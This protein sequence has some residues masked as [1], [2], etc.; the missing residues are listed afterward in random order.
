MAAIQQYKRTYWHE[1]KKLI[2][3]FVQRV[4]IYKRISDHRLISHPNDLYL[5]QEMYGDYIESLT[6]LRFL[7]RVKDETGQIQDYL[8]ENLD[9]YSTAVIY[10]ELWPIIKYEI[11][12]IHTNPKYWTLWKNIILNKKLEDIRFQMRFVFEH[13]TENDLDYA[14]NELFDICPIMRNANYEPIDKQKNQDEYEEKMRRIKRNMEETQQYRIAI[15][16]S[17]S[18]TIQR[19][20][21]N[22]TYIYG[23]INNKGVNAAMEYVP[24]IEYNEYKGIYEVLQQKYPR[25]TSLVKGFFNGRMTNVILVGTSLLNYIND[26]MDYIR[27]TINPTYKDDLVIKLIDDKQV[28][29]MNHFYNVNRQIR[30]TNYEDV[31]N[32]LTCTRMIDSMNVNEQHIYMY[33]LDGTNGLL[34]MTNF[35]SEY[36]LIDKLFKPFKIEKIRKKVRNDV[37]FMFR[38]IYNKQ[39]VPESIDRTELMDLEEITDEEPIEDVQFVKSHINERFRLNKHDMIFIQRYFGSK[40]DFINLMKTNSEYYGVTDQLRRNPIPLETLKDKELF[41]NV[42]IYDFHREES[43]VPTYIEMT[44]GSQ[45]GQ[46]LIKVFEILLYLIRIELYN[47]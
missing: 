33:T 23:L 39:Q 26:L 40:E 3:L 28:R 38:T 2:K 6:P 47:N 9:W 21:F 31:I 32:S 37:D 8:I 11:K 43:V 20:T 35:T 1:E 27:V 30:G 7:N 44:D 36:H 22:I 10:Q 18:N 17:I 45:Y 19:E 42:H 46:K 12:L 41:Q 15:L 16:T 14:L 34:F 4:E 24:Y 29:C 25:V 5:I 13:V